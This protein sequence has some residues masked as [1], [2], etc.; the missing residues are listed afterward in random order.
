MSYSGTPITNPQTLAEFEDLLEKAYALKKSL[1]MVKIMT[2]SEKLLELN[3]VLVEI[4]PVLPGTIVDLKALA[5]ESKDEDRKRYAHLGVQFQLLEKDIKDKQP[6]IAASLKRLSDEE[7]KF[8]GLAP[9]AGNDQKG[10]GST[11]PTEAES[12]DDSDV[13]QQES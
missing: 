8:L 2:N 1:K 12:K 9:E 7:S 13:D 4:L 10:A 5:L 11:E 6:L 3:K